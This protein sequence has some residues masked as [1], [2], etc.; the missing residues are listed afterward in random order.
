MK[1]QQGTFNILH[2]QCK[3]EGQTPELS[4]FKLEPVPVPTSHLIV[5]PELKTTFSQG[6]VNL[7]VSAI[8]PVMKQRCA[9]EHFPPKADPQQVEKLNTDHQDHTNCHQNSA[10]QR[11][12]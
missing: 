12:E 4:T 6:T 8:E 7:H 11:T 1:T 3:N 5:F 10:V 2:D 9:L